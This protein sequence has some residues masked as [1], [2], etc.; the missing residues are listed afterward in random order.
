[1]SEKSARSA[2]MKRQSLRHNDLH[3][4]FFQ[5]IKIK[6]KATQFPPSLFVS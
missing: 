2:L 5:K 4:I 6:S 3:F 1:M